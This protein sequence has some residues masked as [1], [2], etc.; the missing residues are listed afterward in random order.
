MIK[1]LKSA[2]MARITLLLVGWVFA[3]CFM[4]NTS[5]ISIC[6]FKQSALTDTT[7]LTDNSDGIQK[8]CD[9]TEKLLSSAKVNL[10]NLMVPMFLFIVVIVAWLVR[11]R[12]EAPSFTEPIVPK[13]RVHL[14]LCVFRE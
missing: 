11:T 6:S 4:Q 9:L 13:P 5:I 14:T 8:Q 12:P 1:R 3:V 7:Q 2:V 10:D